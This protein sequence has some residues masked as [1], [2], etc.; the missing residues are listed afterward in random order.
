MTAR[1]IRRGAL[2]WLERM[3][4]LIGGVIAIWCLIVIL[5]AQY[6]ARMPVPEP[7][8]IVSALPGE[9]GDD[10]SVEAPARERGSWVAR[11][12][13]PSVALA[14]TV[15]EGSDEGTL[16]R[17][18][19]HIESTAFP[20]ERGNVGI[21]GHRDTVFRPLRRL[22]VGDA[23]RLTTGDRIFQYRVS[24]T[25]IVSPEDVY[26]LNST[27]TSEMTLVTC[28]PFEFI[29]HAP[30]RYIISADLVGEAAR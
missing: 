8:P 10:R 4:F 3:F 9:A 1:N 11:L 13:A 5:R 24:G 23:L 22:H 14:A 29:G 30:K 18:A 27:G 6:Y 19:G 21:A 7:P 16:S 17:A 2:R 15:L 12:E 20:G 28:Y 25:R 26:V